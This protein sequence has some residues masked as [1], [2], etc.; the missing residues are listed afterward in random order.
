MI[1][2]ENK[3]L[4]V[5][6]L[7]IHGDGVV[8]LVLNS[9]IFQN[10]IENITTLRCYRFR[11]IN[12][13]TV[14]INIKRI[15]FNN[16]HIQLLESHYF[17]DLYELTYLKIRDN[18]I[19][20]IQNKTFMDLRKLNKLLLSYNHITHIASNAFAGLYS[21]LLLDL[22]FNSLSVL[23]AHTFRINTNIGFN[24]TKT[25]RYIRLL[26]SELKIIKSR[27]F[28]FDD[29]SS[30]DL[31]YNKISSIEQN[32]FD[33]K[34]I[35]NIYLEGNKLSTISK[36]VFYSITIKNVLRVYGN[37]I[38]CDCELYWIKNH[39]IFEKLKQKRK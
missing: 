36:Q 29:M 33:I 31:S 6:Q 3:A 13:T 38:T 35:E 16:L 18:N 34:I 9:S 19:S 39:E 27:L 28:I 11:L 32:A 24:I 12:L 10:R 21:L 14:N 5:T 22:N 4:N 20:T 23:D 7:S 26:K 17:K 30:I 2:N 1:Y 25:I 15:E 37:K 8:S